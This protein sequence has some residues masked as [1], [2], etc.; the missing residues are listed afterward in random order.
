MAESSRRERES[1]SAFIERLFRRRD[2]D[3]FEP[4]REEIELEWEGLSVADIEADAQRFRTELSVLEKMNLPAP[5]LLIDENELIPVA[6]HTRYDGSRHFQLYYEF[7]RYSE[8]RG[9]RTFLINEL[10]SITGRPHHQLV[11][12]DV[13]RASFI[14]RATDFLATRIAGLRRYESASKDA[15]TTLN[16][17]QRLKGARI[18]APGCTF[19]VNTNNPGL[20]VFWSGAYY[21]SGNYFG[22]PTSPAKSVL[23]A[24]TYIFGVDGGAYG[25]MVQWDHAKCKLPGR[26]SIHLN[27]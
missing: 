23:L 3:I 20:R 14:E 10:Y 13:A 5:V 18:A 2:Q 24:G 15:R 25:S 6:L 21:L 27:F 16:V 9:F 12:L 17:F 8:L 22:H 11:P 19:S 7:D 1:A 4:E 26:A